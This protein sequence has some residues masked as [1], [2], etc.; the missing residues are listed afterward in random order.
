MNHNTVAKA[1]IAWQGQLFS[2]VI[3]SGFKQ[4]HLELFFFFFF[5]NICRNK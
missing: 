2:N 1:L 5:K 4:L 3:F